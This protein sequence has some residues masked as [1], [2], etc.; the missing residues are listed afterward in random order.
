MRVSDVSKINI[1][2]EINVGALSYAGMDSSSWMMA[3]AFLVAI[4]WGLVSVGRSKR[5][6]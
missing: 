2:I 6:Y 1:Q 4:F 5:R 3:L